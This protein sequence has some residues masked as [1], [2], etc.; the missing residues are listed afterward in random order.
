[1]RRLNT[2]LMASLVALTL[3]SCSKKKD[4]DDSFKP[5]YNTNI[6]CKIKMVGHYGNFEG[7]ESEIVRFNEFYPNVELVYTML[8][9]YNNIISTSLSSDN[10]PDLFFT[11]PWML[12][13]NLY[14]EVFSYAE[15]LSD[16]N[17]D[18]NLS[19][20]REGLIYR[21]KDGSIP[22]VPIY[23]T[24][25]GM[26]VNEDLFKK[27]SL[28]IPKTYNELVS[29][30]QAFKN[31]GYENPMM[32][33][34]SMIMY[35]MY[36]PHFCA[37]IKDNSDAV[38]KLNSLDSSAAEYMRPSLNLVKSFMDNG[39][40]DLEE[41]NALETDYEAVIARF[42]KGDVPMMLSSAN[43]VSGTKKREPSDVFK[44]SFHPV[45]STDKGGYFLN[46][47]SLCFSVNKESENL[48]MAN[49][50]MRFIL[51]TKELGNLSKIKRMITSAKD[52][53]LDKMYASFE[54]VEPIYLANLGLKDDADK[55]VRKAG[56]KV[57]T[58]EMTVDEA[59]NNFGNFS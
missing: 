18:I 52:M 42:F 28:N 8:N 41:C 54:A 51:T 37:G 5:R 13:N 43:T 6:N 2:V 16:S 3:V 33:H 59:I 29:T 34:N 35:P 45:P 12:D 25:F 11:Y 49:E 46:S 36:F 31:K 19:T 27:E 57:A 15:D 10:S 38:N 14:D 4:T 17:V 23:T 21:D 56:I 22:M 26:L 47:V 40:I 48:D 50:F 20:I 55:Q 24:T 9:D 44:Y 30:C 53:S 7:I 1:M 58:G 39:F 32:G